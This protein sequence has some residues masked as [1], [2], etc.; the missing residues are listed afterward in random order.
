M[1]NHSGQ[2]FYTVDQDNKFTCAR[3]HKGAWWFDH[4][5]TA[6]LNGLYYKGKTNNK[7]ADGIVWITWKGNDESLEWTEIKIRPKYFRPAFSQE[8]YRNNGQ[9]M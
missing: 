8:H 7:L 9:I 2:N 6:H 1:K 4:C 3:N 5:K